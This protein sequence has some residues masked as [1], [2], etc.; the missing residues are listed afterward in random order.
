MHRIRSHRAATLA[1]FEKSDLE[2]TTKK[3]AVVEKPVEK[4][5]DVETD[6][7]DDADA[8]VE[9]DEQ[10]AAAAKAETTDPESSKR[11]AAITQAEKRAREKI[12]KERQETS[13]ARAELERAKASLDAERVEFEAWKKAKARA[14][15][16]PVAYLEA[17]GVDDLEYAAKMAYGK[18]KAATDPANREAAARMMREREQSSDFDALKQEVRDLKAQL[19][20]KEQRNEFE[21][22]R[23]T[24]LDHAVKAVPDDAPITR[25]LATKNPVKLRAAL[26]ATTVE[27]TD[28]ND[29]D[30][31]DVSEVIAHYEKT[32]RA[33]L[34]ELGIDYA[35]TDTKKNLQT[36]DKKHPAKT[37]GNDLSTPRVPRPAKSEREQRAE[38]LALLES[39]KLE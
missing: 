26:W 17:G 13:A 5:V 12:T 10:P 22:S 19:T 7:Q 37:L 3:V 4:P 33:E 29:G 15:L 21:T 38:T 25:A 8:G 11:L 16:D 1:E 24:Y 39:G 27:L 2:S 23:S 32:R 35:A 9:T 31:P 28:A 14:K 20:Q 36:A 18:A 30:V 34:D 6:T